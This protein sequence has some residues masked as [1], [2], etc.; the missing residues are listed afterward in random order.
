LGH[1][2]RCSVL[3]HLV[4]GTAEDVAEDY[5]TIIHELESYGGVLADKPRV[6]VLNK[7][8]ALLEEE[9]D[10]K[11]AALEE[12]SGGRVWVMSGVS[13]EG[14][15]QVLRALRAEISA[16]RLR[17]RGGGAEEDAGSWQP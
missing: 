16:D 3:L 10:E 1:V 5:N 8:D 13:K 11:K 9:V 17:E 7:A 15:T 12:A 14:V 2:E 6:T 4:D